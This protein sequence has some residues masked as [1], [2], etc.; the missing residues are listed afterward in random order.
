MAYYQTN[1]NQPPMYNPQ[2]GAQ[3]YYV[4][5]TSPSQPLIVHN[6]VAYPTAAPEYSVV[7]HDHHHRVHRMASSSFILAIC[8]LFFFPGILSVLAII[9]GGV[10]LSKKDHL[11]CRSRRLAIWGLTVGIIGLIWAPLYL[12]FFFLPL[13]TYN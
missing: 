4:Q 3:V 13:V 8:G 1:P 7:V 9:F 6:N 11:D 12:L 2:L 10:A 5:P